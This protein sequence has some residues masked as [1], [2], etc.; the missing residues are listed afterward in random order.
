MKLLDYSWLSRL[1]MQL[2]GP[3]REQS[4]P[5]QETLQFK[6]TC[7]AE[8]ILLDFEGPIQTGVDARYDRSRLFVLSYLRSQFRV[9]V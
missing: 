2:W 6:K 8:S 7:I 9:N 4:L 1:V 5:S 3:L